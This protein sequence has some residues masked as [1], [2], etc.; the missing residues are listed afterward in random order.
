MRERLSQSQRFGAIERGIAIPL[1]LWMVAALTVTL[2][3]VVYLSRDS[4]NMAELRLR[5]A[6]AYAIARGAAQL[7]V[8]DYNAAREMQPQSQANQQGEDGQGA[9]VRGTYSFGDAQAHT[10]I[11]P[12]SGFVSISE[13]NQEIW[14]KLLSGAGGLEVNSA[15]ALAETIVAAE[16]SGDGAGGG[17]PMTFGSMYKPAQTTGGGH[18]EALLGVPGMSRTVYDRIVAY[19]SP[20]SSAGEF[21]EDMAP[22]GLREAMRVN[23]PQIMESEALDPQDEGALDVALSGSGHWCVEVTSQFS[24]TEGYRQRVW[25]SAGGVSRGASAKLVRIEPP[26]HVRLAGAN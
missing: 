20:F 3:G 6:Q 24:E 17:G 13:Q 11:Y 2:S 12:A 8:R 9:S 22:E 15:A 19:I 7:A 1:V 18:L 16:L 5:E 14:A 10:V 23:D 25:V 4:I 26:H 21:A